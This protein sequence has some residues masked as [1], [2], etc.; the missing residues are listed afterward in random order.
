MKILIVDDHQLFREGLVFI[1]ESLEE[2]VTILQAANYDGA[3]EI[4][5][6]HADLDIVLLDLRMPGLDGYSLLET[7]SISYPELRIAVLS[8]SR[9]RKEIQRAINSS[10]VGFIPKDTSSKL[11]LNA[12][13]MML[14]GGMYLPPEMA[15]QGEQTVSD[16]LDLTP[17]QLDV[18]NMIAAGAS[19]KV[20]AAE[21]GISEST[22]KMHTTAVFKALGVSNRTQAALAVQEMS[23]IKESL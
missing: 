19:N 12:V 20:I 1:L 2:G 5:D 14:D 6:E 4:M 8:A 18:L 13:R 7:A 21:L 22:I 23:L 3:L 11:L 16:K 10:A 9:D 17:R 15:K